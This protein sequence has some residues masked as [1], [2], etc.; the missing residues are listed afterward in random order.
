MIGYKATACL[1]KFV[2]DNCPVFFGTEE[3]IQVQGTSSQSRTLKCIQTKRNIDTIQA[4]KVS[5][6]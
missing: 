1:L 5:I 6:R 4:G 3:T 2:L